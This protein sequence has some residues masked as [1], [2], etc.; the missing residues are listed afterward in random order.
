MHL[1]YSN[2]TKVIYVL[3]L[4]AIFSNSSFCGDLFFFFRSLA[5]TRFWFPGSMVDNG[6]ELHNKLI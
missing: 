4:L 5:S 1:K 6:R 2:R 3:N